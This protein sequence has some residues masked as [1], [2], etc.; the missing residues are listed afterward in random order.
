MEYILRFLIGG[1]V[2]SIFA[3]IG[4]IIRPKSFAG[5]FGAAPTVALATLGLTFAKHSTQY[6]STEGRSMLLG[7]VAMFAYSQF[8]ALLLIRKQWSSLP[9][10]IGAYVIWLAVA[11][12]L[13]FLILR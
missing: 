11:F 6:V 12:G 5:L 3:V 9:L 13:W 7:A 4:D 2:V 1:L 8:T 10:S